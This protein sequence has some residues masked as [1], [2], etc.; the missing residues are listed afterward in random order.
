M[1][2]GRFHQGPR[3]KVSL[4]RGKLGK[5]RARIQLV[6]LFWFLAALFLAR[7]GVRLRSGIDRFRPATPPASLLAREVG[8]ALNN[9]LAAPLR[10]ELVLYGRVLPYEYV[11]RI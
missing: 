1:S 3:S 2:P 11:S 10:A 9:V 6:G 7:I 5:R 8:Q 4:P